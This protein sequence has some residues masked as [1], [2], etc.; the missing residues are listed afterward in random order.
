M[1]FSCSACC[2]VRSELVSCQQMIS[3][4]IANYPFVLLYFQRIKP[5]MR[6]A[7]L[8]RNNRYLLNSIAYL[9]H[10]LALY[11]EKFEESYLP[12]VKRHPKSRERFWDAASTACLTPQ[13]LPHQDDLV[14]SQSCQADK[15]VAADS[16]AAVATIHSCRF[17]QQ[18]PAG[19]KLT[20]LH[21]SPPDGGGDTCNNLVAASPPQITLSGPCFQGAMR[22]S[23]RRRC[24]ARPLGHGVVGSSGCGCP[25]RNI[26]KIGFFLLG[27]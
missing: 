1:L 24:K 14:I 22:L 7:R 2:G 16:A 6:C 19:S 25:P 21:L 20:E 10:I 17:W 27:R 13:A 26:A 15:V 18:V 11:Q 9:Y 23:C 4:F 5:K 8:L 3:S 12:Q